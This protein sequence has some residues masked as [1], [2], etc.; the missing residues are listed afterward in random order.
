MPTRNIK[1]SNAFERDYAFYLASLDIFS[2][3]G[4]HPPQVVANESGHSAKY[5]FHVYDSTGKMLLC[6]E[7]QLLQKLLV[8]KAS[9]NF[10]VKL[11]AQGI[12][13]HVLCPPELKEMCIEYN[14]PDWVFKAT[15]RQSERELMRQSRERQCQDDL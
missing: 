14:A 8:C 12:K 3:S 13:Q 11:W 9:V 5:C 10:H 1:Y 2:F 4:K 15:L 7:P 6:H